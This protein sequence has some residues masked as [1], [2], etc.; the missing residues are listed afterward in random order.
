MGIGLTHAPGARAF[1]A[2]DGR[3]QVHGFVEEQ[4]RVLDGSFNE[5]ADLAQWYNVLTLE[6]EFDIAPNG[7][8][9]IDLLQAYARIEVRYDCVY[10]RGCGT[11]RS[12]NTYGDRAK[13]LPQRLRDA[14]DP[15]YGGVIR[16]GGGVIPQEV[17][18]IQN[19][20]PSTWAQLQVV[21]NQLQG[22]PS[23]P[24]NSAL[25]TPD[26][27]LFNNTWIKN[28]AVSVPGTVRGFNPALPESIYNRPFI[29]IVRDREGFPGF[30]TLYKTRGADAILADN[31]FGHSLTEPGVT[32]TSNDDPATYTFAPVEDYLW[33][34][35]EKKG[36]DGGTGRTM[37]MGPW[38][39]KNF[40]RSIGTLRDRANPFRGI[41]PPTRNSLPNTTF[42]GGSNG[43]TPRTPENASNQVTSR[44]TNLPVNS[45]GQ[46]Y[47]TASPTG[48]TPDPRILDFFLDP[49][50]GYRA[51][52]NPTVWV[53]P[54]VQTFAGF[55]VDGTGFGGDFSGI[56]PFYAPD[57]D[58]ITAAYK[59][60]FGGFSQT[61][62][63]F[64]LTNVRA[65]GGVVELPAR[66]GPDKSNL[67]AFDEQVAQGLYLP[68][69][70]LRRALLE[71]DFDSHEFNYRQAE[72]AWNRGQSQQETKEV[73]EAYVDAEVLDSRLWMRFGL[74]NIVWGKT[75]L[76]RTTDQFNPQDL[77]LASLASLEESR[78]ALFAGRFVYSLYDVG[79]LEDVRAEFAFNF[80][81]YKPAD[82]GA[83][84]EAFTPDVVCGITAGLFFHGLTGIGI[85]G[86]DRPPNPWE[87]IKGLEIGGR[88]EWRW[89]R[90][91]FA[92][93]DF[94]GYSDFP[95][96]DAINYYERNVD[97]ETG[98]PRIAG[99]TGS[100]RTAGV[101]EAFV[102]GN[103]FPGSLADPGL[104]Q[105]M[106]G[107][108][109]MGVDPDCLKA[110]GAASGVNANQWDPEDYDD[111]LAYYANP[112]H[113][114]TN[115]T[116]IRPPLL[117]DL[118]GS[119]PQNALENQSANQQIFAFI[120][121]GTVTIAASVDPGA[122]AWSIFGTARALNDA[123]PFLGLSEIFGALFAGEHNHEAQGFFNTFALNTKRATNEFTPVRNLNDDY[124]DGIIT[125]FVAV[126]T[127]AVS[128]VINV[129]PL[130]NPITGVPDP[131]NPG[132]DML[133][134][135]QTLTNEQ[136]ALLGCGP[137][138]GTRCDS[139]R[140]GVILAPLAP[141][142]NLN[143]QASNNNKGWAPGGG[144]DVL[145][146][147]ASA[148]LQAF[149]GVEGTTDGW[150]TT[151]RELGPQPGTIGFDGGPVCTRYVNG[152]LVVLPGCRGVKSL[153]LDT[154]TGRYNAVFDN[155]YNVRQD[156][157]VFGK[158]NNADAVVN[159]NGKP[160]DAFHQDGSPVTD[161]QTCAT[162]SRTR[163]PPIPGT[164]GY[165]IVQALNLTQP[166][167]GARTLWHPLAGCLSAAQSA[168]E[169]TCAFATRNFDV[170]FETLDAFG[171]PGAQI[172]SNELAALSWNLMMFL[173]TAGSCDTKERAIQ[174]DPE[175]FD[176]LTAWST[177]KCGFAAPQYC[178][179]VKGFLGV[180][181]PNSNRVRAGGNGKYGRRDF[182]WHSGGE[183]ALRYAKRNVF[184]LSTDFAEDVS[185]TNWSMEFTWIGATPYQDASDFEN[186]I[187]DSDSVNLTVSVDRPTFINF[188]NAN[189]TF[190]FN[191]QW[192]F[193]YL[194][195]YN[196]SFS[197][198]GPF[199]VLFTFAMFTGYYQDRLLP[200]LVSVYDFNSRSGGLLPSITYRFN[201]AFSITT[202]V[203][204]FWGRGQFKDMPVRAFAPTGNRTG[205]HAYD[206]GVENVLSAINRRDEVFLRL[207]YTF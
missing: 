145:N 18:R 150:T 81:R 164:N 167:Q 33:T 77:A 107:G 97:P 130:F 175:C 26:Q 128:S 142:Q 39:P 182:I 141:G 207:R 96:P 9:P 126:P 1:E 29:T 106:Q 137:F 100:C 57:L 43:Q 199:N 123:A 20:R 37:I 180:G 192:F 2:F 74:Q 136:R 76:F 187:T 109:G 133:T 178:G 66:P 13:R 138:Y 23:D 5:E 14:R 83:C 205:P 114:T 42:F 163:Q 11:M 60:T 80:D 89:D 118:P 32:V 44:T 85:V 41:T 190:F 108:L 98:R 160:V 54:D 48:D 146:A 152:S 183:L 194:T 31:P 102:F 124:T 127:G 49:D 165:G 75:E 62:G 139:G 132:A 155:G 19:E 61:N 69:S 166:V 134:M 95:Y 25:W 148:I 200:T 204:W 202:G 92:L 112:F 144:L 86:V 162:S 125:A 103:F 27:A 7:F 3:V 110:G 8:G 93:I 172:F 16:T 104:V 71:Q 35:R 10:S 45:F 185:K 64:P 30:D 90:F 206:D 56:V 65:V 189:R 36:P 91:S 135:D 113:P 197:T 94:W 122:C 176:P 140:G 159:I 153:T 73:K 147:E 105:P 188:L 151:N 88:L 34:F 51:G 169:T 6:N 82:L 28:V 79:P 58:P 186:G 171:N 116:G 195:N 196:S 149:P 4:I 38:L 52:A 72:R 24:T 101:F 12:V 131:N 157:C 158:V 50:N 181:G 143:Y 87:S 154:G 173:I 170:Q 120:C 47:P 184:G 161:F 70:N 179:S 59:Q 203:N 17:P 68:S 193:Q 129:A 156:G 201:E 78:I 40:I 21:P 63:V 177:D 53:F 15:E 119:S 191:S 117:Y 115:P 84:G 168:S 22:D 67:E 55:R 111:L 121:S 46:M 174:E 198:N 99:A